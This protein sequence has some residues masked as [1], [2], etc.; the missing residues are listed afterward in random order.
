MKQ[1]KYI[2]LLLVASLHLTM[3]R[4]QVYPVQVT[5][6]LQMPYPAHLSDYANT[7]ASAEQMQL[8]L[9]LTDVNEF[10]RQVRLEVTIKG[11]NI[12]AKS[13]TV[14]NGATPVYLDGGVPLRL[15]NADLAPYFKLENLEGISAQAY[16]RQLPAGIYNFCFTVYDYLSGQRLSRTTCRPVQII[17]Y[18]PPILN[19]PQNHSNIVFAEPQNIVFNWTPR[20]IGAFNT[21][22]E[23][24]LVEVW[25]NAA[26]SQS[27]FLSS[28]PL[29][30]TT[31]TATSMLYGPAEPL[32]IAGKTYAW[33]VQAKAK[34]GLD[35]I[36][37]F[38]NQG[39]T[40]IFTFTLEEPCQP[41][42]YSTADARVNNA[43]ISFDGLPRHQSHTLYLQPANSRTGYWYSYPCNGNSIN[44]NQLR[45]GTT[46]H[47]YI[48]SLCG[49]NNTVESQHFSFTT[50]EKE[51]AQFENCG[52]EGKE[53]KIT[54]REPIGNLYPG[55][56]FTAAGHKITIITVSGS[57]GNF[58]GTGYSEINFLGNAKIAV[59]FNNITVN[60]DFQL[61]GGKV[62]STYNAGESG[63]IDAEKYWENF[64]ETITD[65]RN[66]QET[67]ATQIEEA[68]EE[69]DQQYL[70]GELSYDDYQQKQEDLEEA[71]QYLGEAGKAI[72]EA[73]KS[74]ERK[75]ENPE[76]AAEEAELAGNHQQNAQEALS[77]AK[78]LAGLS[79]NS[80]NVNTLTFD[81]DSY[82]DGVLE[83]SNPLTFNYNVEGHNLTEIQSQGITSNSPIKS[84]AGDYTVFIATPSMNAD[85]LQAMK[86]EFD[87]WPQ[88]GKGFAI[89]L[90]YSPDAKTLAYK[91]AWKRG[92]MGSNEHEIEYEALKAQYNKGVINLLGRTNT[93]YPDMADQLIDVTSQLNGFI[94]DVLAEIR[95][96][97][98]LWN[99]AQSEYDP[100]N[101]FNVFP[102][103]SGVI[104]GVVEES[105][106][107]LN[108]VTLA[109]D[110]CTDEETKKQINEAFSNFNLK[111]FILGA[112][113]SYKDRLTQGSSEEIQY[114]TG[115]VGTEIVY[116]AT[117]AFAMVKSTKTLV[118]GVIDGVKK[119]GGNIAEN[120]KRFLKNIVDNRSKI[121]KV[122]DTPEGMEYAKK[123]FNTFVKQGNFDDWYK[124]VFKKYELGEP[125]NFEVHHVIPVKVLEKSKELQEL[126]MWAKK[127]GKAFDFNSV[128]NGIP[129]PKKR[130]KYEQSGHASHLKY[131]SGIRRRIND[132]LEN[133]PNQERAF[134]RIENLIKETKAKLE[135]EVLLGSRDVNQIVNF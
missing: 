63:I 72:N 58:S 3:A 60:T 92:F 95:V 102:I 82:F 91:T 21:E 105:K 4:G 9:T 65:L 124:D 50:P 87:S 11:N 27:V 86:D 78:E 108:L 7:M 29:Y 77:K 122:L 114:N 118:D 129:L 101:W 10:Q 90:Y 57:N 34:Q 134:E 130:I 12:A 111:D 13:R 8:L 74:E 17:L 51:Y 113:E 20:H 76:T 100:E 69:T 97:E 80:S 41:V 61:C 81:S 42:S 75:T 54:N 14:V 79:S 135:S 46:Y 62:Q 123:Y 106:D 119:G 71:R 94:K 25:D 96:P 35:H 116:T 45:A 88:T 128:D 30:T 99:P 125:L 117:G 107:L 43:T 121:R 1:L 49:S 40:E 104:D 2:L 44:I 52:Q 39:Y 89:L 85:S 84:T 47:Y 132:I 127:E 6:V 36:S 37:L 103:G 23:L 31:T 28:P 19:L 53:I 120:L 93:S 38:Q 67:L 32:L 33:R 48:E 59:K 83:Q 131:D 5:P 115:N 22:Y 73:E 16:A 109:V 133:A 98:W 126:L 68:A 112:Y 18:E 26:P 56:V 64:K 66:Q 110:Y 70:R 24:S 55:D 15:T